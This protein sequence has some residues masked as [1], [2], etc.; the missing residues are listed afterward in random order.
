M[1]TWIDGL[2]IDKM[3]L[4]QCLGYYPGTLYMEVSATHLKIYLK[5]ATFIKSISNIFVT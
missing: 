2:Y 3:A 1:K 4:A 5:W